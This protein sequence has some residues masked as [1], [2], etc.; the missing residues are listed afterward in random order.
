MSNVSGQFESSKTFRGYPCAHRRWQHDGHC[1]FVHGYSR[2]FTVWFRATQRD[3]NG[4]VMDFG[5]LK[6]VKAWLEDHF[7]HTLLLDSDDPWLPDFQRL[8]AQGA[9]KL[10]VFDDVGMEGTAKWVFDWLDPWVQSETQGR[11]WV[12]S[13]EVRE[14]DKNSGRFTRLQPP[15]SL[16]K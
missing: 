11:V 9:C 13:I 8:E 5:K 10:A 2:S 15:T 16:S 3:D 4:F 12:H 14:N 1:A 6:P 7:D